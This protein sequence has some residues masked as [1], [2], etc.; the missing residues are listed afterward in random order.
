M[1][2][3]TTLNAGVKQRPKSRHDQRRRK[4][5]TTGIRQDTLDRPVAKA[6]VIE[7]V[8]ANQRRGLVVSIHFVTI[9]CEVLLRQVAQLDLPRALKVVEIHKAG[10]VNC[11]AI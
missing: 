4:P 9:C 1:K 7:I 11:E 5:V 3:L 6:E 8:S 10:P 2:I